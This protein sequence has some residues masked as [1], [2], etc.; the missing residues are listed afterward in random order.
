MQFIIDKTG[1]IKKIFRDNYK[2]ADSS[3]EELASDLFKVLQTIEINETRAVII[4]LPLFNLPINKNANED[5]KLAIK[6]T[7]ELIAYFPI[8]II[9]SVKTTLNE[10]ELCLLMA[11]HLSIAS[12]SAKFIFS[13]AFINWANGINFNHDLP[14]IIQK[15]HLD[16]LSSYSKK[17][18]A[19]EAIKLGLVN[20][21]VEVEIVDKACFEMADKIS[22]LAPLAIKACLQAV[23]EGLN[24]SLKKG[25]ELESKLFASIFATKD[26]KE[27]TN[28][29][30]EKR[31]PNFTGN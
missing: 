22:K 30:L 2:I 15:K 3:L 6:K 16:K 1:F 5:F 23:N 21:T 8:P 10:Y 9:T 24:T 12:N 13:N 7:S 18:N 26:M 25:L 19:E 4:D 11:S 27:G 14:N 20:K 31:S 29:F 28:A 17:I